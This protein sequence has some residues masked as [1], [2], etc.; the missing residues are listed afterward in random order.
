MNKNNELQKVLYNLQ[1]NGHAYPI[2]GSQGVYLNK[3]IPAL[4]SI[5]NGNAIRLF[6]VLCESGN[7]FNQVQHTAKEC[8]E[9]AGIKY[10]RGNFSKLLNILIEEELVAMIGN[11]ITINPYVVMPRANVTQKYLL[12]EAWDLLVSYVEPNQKG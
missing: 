5:K 9:A 3:L 10:Y 7:E 12:Q 11:Q 8:A 1:T 6:F 4:N 2:S